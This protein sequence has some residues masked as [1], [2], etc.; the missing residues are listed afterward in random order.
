MK[1]IFHAAL[2]VAL[3]ALALTAC[4][5]QPDKRVRKKWSAGDTD[6]L[7]VRRGG[8]HLPHTTKQTGT[9]VSTRRSPS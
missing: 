9:T 6:P 1:L 3:C 4:G 5:T 2:G 8:E 7:A